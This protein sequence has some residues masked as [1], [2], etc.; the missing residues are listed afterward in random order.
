MSPCL[1]CSEYLSE[2]ESPRTIVSELKFKVAKDIVHIVN[3]LNG[4]YRVIGNV[5]ATL[6]SSSRT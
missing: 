4:A 3:N 2:S 6:I 5:L 1:L